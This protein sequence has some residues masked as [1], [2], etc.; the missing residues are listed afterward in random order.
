[1]QNS[2]NKQSTVKTQS[3]KKKKI[4]TRLTQSLVLSNR[5]LKLTMTNVLE[6]MV[7]SVDNRYEQMRNFSRKDENS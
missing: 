5:E 4:Q 2:E 3:N 1:M 7:G 6:R